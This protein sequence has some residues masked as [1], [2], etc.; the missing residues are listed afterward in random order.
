M[1]LEPKEHYVQVLEDLSPLPT[2]PPRGL[3]QEIV[4]SL[5]GYAHQLAL[6]E[7]EEIVRAGWAN[8]PW[9]Q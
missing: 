3:S 6:V 8:G 9:R 7:A 2:E 1:K 5:A 4:G